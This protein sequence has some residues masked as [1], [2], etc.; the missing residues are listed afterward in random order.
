M[1]PV[2][3][4][5]FTKSP[6]LLL[7]GSSRFDVFQSG[8]AVGVARLS[9]GLYS[10][11]P[12]ICSQDGGELSLVWGFHALREA[13][14][15]GYHE[16]V[17]CR[18]IADDVPSAL[19]IAL[20]FEQRGGSYTTAEQYAVW[21]LLRA[22]RATGAA[23]TNNTNDAAQSS[24]AR[25]LGLSWPTYRA[26]MAR[27]DAVPP[28]ARAAVLSERVDLKTAERCAE[29]PPACFE[30]LSLPS[31][32]AAH[33]SFSKTRQ[34]LTLLREICLRDNLG[35]VACSE[36]H[37][38][39]LM[40]ADRTDPVEFLRRRRFPG[41]VALEE[42]FEELRRATTAAG[43]VELS[44]PPYFEGDA[45]EVRFS[46]SSQAELAR[47]RAVLKLIED[48]FHEFSELL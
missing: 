40:A 13:G 14:T 30:R 36:L 7:R 29:L 35:P 22:A 27:L 8:T 23:D 48:R 18:C 44:A 10:P 20:E 11:F 45:F 32:S 4:R 12:V 15:A 26:H 47:R 2:D 6:E 1:S 24:I 21:S 3:D 38:Q 42:R 19:Q 33:L 43:G 16:P 5:T 28:P 17:L 37:E 9:R 39:A 46:F 31:H 34:V 25:Q 41:L